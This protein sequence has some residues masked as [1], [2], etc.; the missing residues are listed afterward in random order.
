ML[1]RLLTAKDRCCPPSLAT[2][3]LSAA[4]LPAAAL[5]V[6]LSTAGSAATFAAA[7]AAFFAAISYAAPAEPGKG[8]RCWAQLRLHQP[9]VHR[10]VQLQRL[11]ASGLGARSGAKGW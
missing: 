2:A 6:A 5:S 11:Q 4:A 7:A 1:L 10:L 3:V 9:W 8:G